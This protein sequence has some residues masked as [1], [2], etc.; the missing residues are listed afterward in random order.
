MNH[1]AV[2][3]DMLVLAAGETRL[4]EYIRQTF[5]DAPSTQ[6]TAEN[7][8]DW[9]DRDEFT[10]WLSESARSSAEDDFWQSVDATTSPRD[11]K[12][13]DDEKQSHT[14]GPQRTEGQKRR[15][16]ALFVSLFHSK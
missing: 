6:Y 3:I 8:A 16:S 14:P 2:A 10:R 13:Q 1:G 4:A 5:P 11:G 15:L 12:M 9:L 7:A